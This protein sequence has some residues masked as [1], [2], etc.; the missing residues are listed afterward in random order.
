MEKGD[1][2]AVRDM[3]EPWERDFSPNGEFR[4]I[5]VRS[6]AY[7][8][9]GEPINAAAEFQ[10]II[11]HRGVFPIGVRY[12]LAFVQQARAYAL[13]GDRAKA[14]LSYERFFELWKDADPDVPILKDARA[15][16]AR[17]Q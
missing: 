10:R 9:A 3:P 17:L 1:R 16:S 4:S 13:V 11:D 2:T 7:M 12:P 14:G 5:Y 15:E 6:L 8:R